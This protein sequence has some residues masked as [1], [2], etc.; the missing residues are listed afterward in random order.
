[1]SQI[2]FP[3]MVVCNL[4]HVSVSPGG[5]LKYKLLGLIPRVF[6]PVG[7]QWGCGICLSNEFPDEDDTLSWKPHF[8]HHSYSAAPSACPLVSHL[9]VSGEKVKCPTAYG[10]GP[11]LP[12]RHSSSPFFFC[13]RAWPLHLGFSLVDTCTTNSVTKGLHSPHSACL[14]KKG[15]PFFFTAHEDKH[16]GCLLFM[17][18]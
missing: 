6:G 5:L 2:L 9:C 7:Q 15:T 18:F 14:L 13:Y 10:D 17:G 16:S 11:Q 8:D 4:V 3:S 1:M 12:P